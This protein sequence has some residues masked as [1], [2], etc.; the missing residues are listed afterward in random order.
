[1]SARGK[2]SGTKPLFRSEAKCEATD[3]NSHFHKKDSER[4]SFTNSEIN[5]LT[6]IRRHGMQKLIQ[7]I[8]RDS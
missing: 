4:E 3:T 7:K 8:E 1:M 2:S 5:D 6:D